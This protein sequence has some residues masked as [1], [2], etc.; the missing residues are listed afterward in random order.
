[1]VVLRVDETAVTRKRLPPRARAS[2][3]A[4]SAAARAVVLPSTPT[5]TIFPLGPAIPLP[6]L[7]RCAAY[8][9]SARSVRLSGSANQAKK[10]FLRCDRVVRGR[11]YSTR[12]AGAVTAG[13]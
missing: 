7:R 11:K 4:V 3:A 8:R 12:Y 1:M 9:R 6:F 10:Y 5:T 2:P 13:R